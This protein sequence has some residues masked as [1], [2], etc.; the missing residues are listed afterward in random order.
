M[1][2][3]IRGVIL[4]MTGRLTEFADAHTAEYVLTSPRARPG[5][6][7]LIP[8]SVV[9]ESMTSHVMMRRSDCA[10]FCG[11]LRCPKLGEACPRGCDSRAGDAGGSPLSISASPELYAALGRGTS[12]IAEI[13]GTPESDWLD[14]KQAL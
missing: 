10:P 12:G 7:L 11:G 2:S 13:R 8:L 3:D 1:L 14:F 4:E 6:S 5:A 9:F